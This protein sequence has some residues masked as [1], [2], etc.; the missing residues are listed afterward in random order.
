MIYRGFT[1]IINI[2]IIFA[3]KISLSWIK[4]RS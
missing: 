2:I 4:I 1:F 3:I